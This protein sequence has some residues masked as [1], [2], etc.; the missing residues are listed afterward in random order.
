MSSNCLTRFLYPAAILMC[1]I[2]TDAMAGP[3][4]GGRGAGNVNVRDHRSP[5]PYAGPVVRDH[6]TQPVVRDH[7]SSRPTLP[8]GTVVRDHRDRPVVRDHRTP[9]IPVRPPIR[10][11]VNPPTVP[12]VRPPV[13]PPIHPLPPIDP[14]MGNGHHGGNHG[15]NHG[16]HHGGHHVPHLPW[17]HARP[18]HCCWW[19]DYCRPLRVCSPDAYVRCNWRVVKCA[20]VVVGDVIAPATRWY[21]GL[22]GMV[23]PGKGLGIEAVEEGSPAALAGLQPGMVIV[24]C[25]GIA[26]VDEESVAEAIASSGGALRLE[27]LQAEGAK[28]VIVPIAMQRV[29]AVKF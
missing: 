16:G 9:R 4:N 15:G 5:K 14:G 19:F 10:V 26:L 12:P 25:N 20:P 18:A 21:L 27:V 24:R 13:K 8:T 3:R 11:P 2:A 23:L 6:R 28:P 29:S 17:H 22:E 7:R 1:V